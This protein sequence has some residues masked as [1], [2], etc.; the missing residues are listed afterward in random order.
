MDANTGLRVIEDA[1]LPRRRQKRR[2]WLRRKRLE[3]SLR[4]AGLGEGVRKRPE[5]AVAFGS[6]STKSL[7]DTGAEGS[8]I[9][10]AKFQMAVEAGA[11]VKVLPTARLE[12]VT[13][14]AFPV[15]RTVRMVAT[16]L[17]KRVSAVWHVSP[18]IAYES[19]MGMNIIKH[20]LNLV[21]GA[22]EW[23]A[24]LAAEPLI[25]APVALRARW[26]S[27]AAFVFKRVE[28]APGQARRVRVRVRDRDGVAVGAGPAFIEAYGL[29]GLVTLDD[30]SSA[31]IFISNTDEYAK[32]ELQPSQAVG[33]AWEASLMDTVDPEEAGPEVLRISALFAG[34]ESVAFA[35][36]AK[37]QFITRRSAGLRKTHW[38]EIAEQVAEACA[39]VQNPKERAQLSALIQKYAPVFSAHKFDIGRCDE[40]THTIRLK[41]ADPVFTKQF[42]LPPR[43]VDFV[44]TH[45]KKW[46]ELKLV[47]PA[48]SPYNSPIFCVSKKGEDGW[49]LVLDYRKLNAQSHVDRYSI[50]SVE[51]CLQEVGRAESTV[52]SALDLTAGFYQLPLDPRI[53]HTT[54][55]TVPG[56]GQFQWLAAPMGLQGSPSSFSRLMDKVLQG[57]TNTVT[58]VDD[59]LVHSRSFAAHMEHLEQVFSRLL[60]AGLKLNL[61]KCRLGQAE[62][63]YLGH[64][65]S[66]AGV[67]PGKD[68]HKALLDTKPPE[69]ITALRS[70][71]GLANFFRK[72]VA[73]FAEKAAPLHALT[74]QTSDW[75]K[76]PM[77]EEAI[78][79]FE[80]LKKDITSA[81]PLALPRPAG[82][83]HLY[84]DAASGSYDEGREGGMGACLMQ[85]QNGVNVPVAFASRALSPAERNYSA[86]LLEKAAA[87][88]AIEH[89]GHL[90]R[91]QRFYLYSDNKP[92]VD[93]T[94]THKRTLN[95]LQEKQNEFEF[96]VRYTPGGAANPADFLSRAHGD[97]A[98]VKRICCLMDTAGRIC[99]F[100]VAAAE[101]PPVSWRDL[102][103]ADPTA[104]ALRDFL[105]KKGKLP[106]RFRPVAKELRLEFGIVGFVLKPRKGFARDDRFRIYPPAAMQK[107]LL[108]EAHDDALAGHGAY[109]ATVE[110]LRERFW[111]PGIHD[112]VKKHVK[113]CKVC[114]ATKPH[115]KSQ[116]P[117]KPIRIPTRPN[118][119]IHTDLWGPHKIEDGQ[120][121]YVCVTTDALTKV[122][123]LKVIE[124]KSAHSVSEALLDW[125]VTYGIPEEVVS[126]NGKEFCNQTVQQLWDKLKIKHNT[127]TPYHP[128]ANGA[129]ERFNRDMVKYLEKMMLQEGAQAGEWPAFIPALMLCHNTS[130]HK[131]TKNSPFEVMFGYTP[132]TIH[133]QN[134]EDIVHRQPVPTV[135]KEALA[136]LQDTRVEVR[137]AAKDVL[138]LQQQHMLRASER[139]RVKGTPIWKPKPR[140]QVWVRRMDLNIPNPTLAQKV[141]PGTVLRCVAPDVY[142]VSR[143]NRKHKKEVTLGIDMLSPKMADVPEADP[144]LDDFDEKGP[145]TDPVEVAI[146][147]IRLLWDEAMTEAFET[148][149]KEWRRLGIPHS[150]TLAI[151]G[152]PEAATT[153]AA[154]PPTW[155]EVVQRST[156]QYPPPPRAGT[157]RAGGSP[158]GRGP[159]PTRTPQSRPRGAAAQEQAEGSEDE[160]SSDFRPAT[161]TPTGPV[162]LTKKNSIKRRLVREAG[163]LFNNEVFQSRL[164]SQRGHK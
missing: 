157:P 132:N 98:K 121:R 137:D 158:W 37:T 19:I 62:V 100:Q 79:A 23:D 47:E 5:L 83:F 12:G 40:Q 164:R 66:A 143:T 54:A 57:A 101:A 155:A 9:S 130:V 61:P 84:V 67:T 95:R 46:L 71:L 72:F 91:G 1:H 93:L 134:V 35:A 117:V 125:C 58:F 112:Q 45:V 86:F 33:Y 87:L 106:A 15:D 152:M 26:T 10:S 75:H 146:A 105:G 127:T 11:K 131:G 120:K 36:V 80:V 141:E 38:A 82:T 2:L 27:G 151:P 63:P 6:V 55:F 123:R 139:A 41:S 69:T 144:N 97:D 60:R 88:Y 65:L 43:E 18:A 78:E 133:R 115:R 76:G 85:Q 64:T 129:A 51:E 108:Q 25:M 14:E 107:Q 128:R 148:A 110:R 114:D 149:T 153:T 147:E 20:G 70:F 24:T 119:R 89:F 32:L 145:E 44:K 96:D 7:Y 124:D 92:L 53:K 74:R 22:V 81:Q 49:R 159:P 31:H 28:I 50:R 56:M 116:A 39:H 135:Q 8:V 103:D 154:S 52:F 136:R 68:K 161:D 48:N 142:V 21:K 140:D 113:H 138:Y 4:I 73:N 156:L 122:V 102:Q 99:Q 77:P 90:L 94:S 59:V 150:C 30:R 109:L 42:P 29:T 160:F 111:W 17:G 104:R 162:K 34:P 16:I 126:D 13:G 118:Q 163:R 3:R